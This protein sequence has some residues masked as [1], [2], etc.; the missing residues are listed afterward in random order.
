MKL[1][2]ESRALC[3]LI[4][5]CLA[6]ED[7]IS[8]MLDDKVHLKVFLFPSPYMSRPIFIVHFYFIFS[9]YIQADA[10]DK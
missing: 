10:L 2:P 4:C 9:Y 7:A 3:R 5:S 1:L 6:L 8:E